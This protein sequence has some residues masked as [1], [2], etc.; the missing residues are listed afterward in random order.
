MNRTGSYRALIFLAIQIVLLA[1][2][3]A[4]GRGKSR[5]T[6]ARWSL[7]PVSNAPLEIP[8]LY[9]DPRVVDDAQLAAVLAKLPPRLR[10]PEPRIYNLDHAL[11]FWGPEARFRDPQALSG[12]EIADLLLDHAAFAKAWGPK[13]KP[14]LMPGVEGLEVRVKDGFASSSHVDHVLSTVAEAG[15]SLDYPV[16]TPRGR[17]TVADMLKHSLR[18]FSLNQYEPEFSAL[19]YALHLRSNRPWVSAE[20]QQITF[21]RI[22]ERLMRDPLTDGVC[23]GTHRLYDLTV[24]LRADEKRHLLSPECRT[25]IVGYLQNATARLVAS[26][27]RAGYWD[28]T[29]DNSTTS[30]PADEAATTADSLSPQLVITG[31]VLEWWALSPQEIAPPC[32]TV[33]RAGQWLVRTVGDMEPKQV[34]EGYAYLSH[35]GRALA[36]WRG[37]YPAWFLKHLPAQN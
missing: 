2:L 18:H 9:N 12:G 6:A 23:Y 28:K 16:A 14:L 5:E 37:N 4:V 15:L 29:W 34:E 3:A 33:I 31:H 36:L 24:L 22:A 20:G 21:D 10:G 32:D 7:P 26:Q 8:P 27:R 17:A 25:R 1:G 13:T 35:V 19:V 30:A 11:R